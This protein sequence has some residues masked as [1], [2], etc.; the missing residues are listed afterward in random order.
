[1]HF[2]DIFGIAVGLAM[3]AFAVSIAAGI[4]LSPVTRR[5]VLRLAIHFG[6]FQGIM[7]VLGFMAGSAFADEI[8]AWDHWIA[9]GLLGFLGGKM[10]WE[11]RTGHEKEFKGDPSKGMLLLSLSI[12]TSIDAAAVGISLALLTKTIWYP[13][14]V[15]GVVTGS[16]CVLG[17]AFGNRLG[18]KL[19]R[20]ADALGGFVLVTIG[21]RIFVTHMLTGI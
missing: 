18:P 2:L 9:L 11:S 17:M 4:A 19:E 21:V 8:A 16:L 20:Y 14:V 3:D 5:Q 6:L 12:A 7:P 10:L 1:M 13:A 15:I